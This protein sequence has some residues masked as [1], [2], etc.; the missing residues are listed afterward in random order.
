[1]LTGGKIE[2][3]VALKSIYLINN[4]GGEQ[5]HL[6]LE[7]ALGLLHTAEV[8]GEPDAGSSQHAPPPVLHNSSLLFF[9]IL[10]K[11]VSLYALDRTHRRC[12]TKTLAVNVNL[13]D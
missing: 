13:Y 4:G 5:N 1:M 12:D 10:V 6:T 9:M 2:T 11:H 7:T 3:E 8:I